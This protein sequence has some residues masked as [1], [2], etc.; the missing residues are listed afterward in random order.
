[1]EE[2]DQEL[3]A[4]QSTGLP[5]KLV[6][7]LT[8][9][10][11]PSTIIDSISSP[12]F[13][14]PP[15]VMMLQSGGEPVH[16]PMS[17]LG[18]DRYVREGARMIQNSIEESGRFWGFWR[19]LERCYREVPEEWVSG[20]KGG[21]VLD[22]SDRPTSV[23]QRF[24][25]CNIFLSILLGVHSLT[26]SLPRSCLYCE[27]VCVIALHS[28]RRCQLRDQTGRQTLPPVIMETQKLGC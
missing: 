10:S 17:P 7:P 1:M 25:Q 18:E 21:T 22:L 14:L 27:G 26:A 12:A 28:Q 13:N 24:Q 19:F 3:V 6:L 20:I 4:R 5:P 15:C 23:V 2:K 16:A 9:H 11:A 8:S